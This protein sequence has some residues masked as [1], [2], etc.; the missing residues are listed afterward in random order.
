MPPTPGDGEGRGKEEP[1]ADLQADISLPL[2]PG[3]TS[4]H[5]ES[6]CVWLG[7]SKL[8]F[9]T[10]ERCKF[11]YMYVTKVKVELIIGDNA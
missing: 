3:Q 8:Q 7:S 6:A 4:S 11:N 1:R 9:L 5:L 2:K 10:N